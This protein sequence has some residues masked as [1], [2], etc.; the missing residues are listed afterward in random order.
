MTPVITL[1]DTS[2]T[3]VSQVLTAGTYGRGVWQISSASAGAAVTTATVS[4][5]SLT[6]T[7]QTVAT[8][9]TAQTL[10][11]KA[12]GTASLTVSSVAITGSA[13]TDFTETDTCAGTVLAKNSTCTLKVSFTPTAAGSRVADLAI[14]AN[15]AGGQLLVPLTGTALA[16]GSVTL[17]PSSLSFGTQQVGTTS[18]AQV[19]NIQNVGGTKI[20]LNSVVITAPF[21][22]TAV[23]C[24]GGLAAGA[25]CTY[26]LAFAPT[27]AGAAT[28]SFTVNDTV[29]SQSE[30][31]TGT[32]VLG[33]HGY[34]FAYKPDVCIHGAG[35]DLAAADGHH[36][37]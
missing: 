36:Y 3:A 26:T 25:S 27:Q 18:A 14:L 16:A 12:T 31:L 9:S 15:V 2:S 29:G 13:A 11:L 23:T 7:T 4:P 32:G 8:T 33:P 10:T 24:G 17:L 5:A 22:E 34:A 28:G 1:V 6:F 35:A 37:Q 19:I 30:P 21:K 20:S